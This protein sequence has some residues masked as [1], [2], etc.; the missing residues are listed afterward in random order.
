MVN[1]LHHLTGAKTLLP[2]GLEETL[3]L[4]LGKPEQIHFTGR[5]N[6]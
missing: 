5:G 2:D 1:P 4:R 6:H 3:Q